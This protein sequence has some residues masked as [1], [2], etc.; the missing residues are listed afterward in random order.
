[1]LFEGVSDLVSAFRVF[2]DGVSDLVLVFKVFSM[3]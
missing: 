1:M 3:V 2:L